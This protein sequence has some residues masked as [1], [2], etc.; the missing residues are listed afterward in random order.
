MTQEENKIS[1]QI[2]AGINQKNERDR[3]LEGNKLIVEFMDSGA[4]IKDGIFYRGGTPIC[5]SDGIKYS[6]S[7]V[8]LMPVIFRIEAMYKEVFPGNE[9]FLEMIMSKESPVDTHYTNVLALP[10]STPIQ[11]VFR[12]VVDFIEWHNSTTYNTEQP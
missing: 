2:D 8:W 6:D 9:K 5:K 4:T 7:Y 1:D 12:E 11:E 3:I 10:I